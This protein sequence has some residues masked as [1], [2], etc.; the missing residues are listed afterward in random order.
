[1]FRLQTAIKER[2]DKWNMLL[3]IR[4]RGRKCYRQTDRQTML[5]LIERIAD[6]K[7]S[8]LINVPKRDL[9]FSSRCCSASDLGDTWASPFLRL[10]LTASQKKSQIKAWLN[11][12]WLAS[13]VKDVVRS[14]SMLPFVVMKRRWLVLNKVRANQISLCCRK[15]YK[16]E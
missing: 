8:A 7:D 14:V 13:G 4:G 11:L 6:R 12:S 15:T 3:T 1:M 2:N 5:Y 10:P 9:S 16:K